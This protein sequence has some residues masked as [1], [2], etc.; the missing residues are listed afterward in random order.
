MNFKKFLSV[1]CAVSVFA[2]SA[3]SVGAASN[4][5]P[6]VTKKNT[7]T[8]SSA[9]ASN[10]EK[11]EVN[12]TPVSQS[13]E[14][15]E[16]LEEIK[17]VSSLKDLP[18]VG[19]N[20]FANTSKDYVVS[21]LFEVSLGSGVD[22]DFFANG[23]TV[24]VTFTVNDLNTDI[25]SIWL[26]KYSTDN[27]WHAMDVTKSGTHTYTSTFT[28]FSPVAVCVPSDAATVSSPKTGDT[29]NY[30]FYVVIAACIPA[31]IGTAV[32]ARKKIAE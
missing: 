19:E 22:K 17:S 29:T 5:T 20:P 23:N 27:K 12:V 3:I 1:L 16:A 2:V 7:V 31:L 32:I 21:N 15:S 18:I 13:S 26:H 4:Y 9:V 8:V 24:T 14:A 28:S 10:G 6:S 30:I 25:D 11:V